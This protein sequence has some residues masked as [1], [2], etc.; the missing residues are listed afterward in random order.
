[1]DE[2]VGAIDRRAGKDARRLRPRAIRRRQRFYR[3][4]SSIGPLRRGALRR[5][6]LAAFEDRPSGSIGSQAAQGSLTPAASVSKAQASSR[7]PGSLCSSPS[8]L[9]T[10]CSTVVWS[11]P[12]KRRPISG[13]ERRVSDLGEEHR[14]LTRL[15]DGGGAA[16]GENVGARDAVVA[17][18]QLLDVLDLHPFGL[19]RAD[20]VADGRFRR[21]DRQRR[22]GRRRNALAAG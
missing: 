3:Q 19:V 12:P 4:P 13:S 11:R 22:A 2:A 14:H 6:R 5:D 15:D 20:E 8:I 7:K 21:L 18:D 16:R 17:R 9:R 1:M 10:A